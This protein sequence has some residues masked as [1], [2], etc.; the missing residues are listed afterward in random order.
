MRRA[1]EVSKVSGRQ[2]RRLSAANWGLGDRIKT[3]LTSVRDSQMWH[4]K[5]LDYTYVI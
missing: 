2:K 3:I 1:W 4:G 5:S